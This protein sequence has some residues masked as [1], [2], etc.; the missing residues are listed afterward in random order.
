MTSITSLTLVAISE[1]LPG[2]LFAGIDTHQDTRHVAVVGGTGRPVN[3]CESPAMTT[4]YTQVVA[5]FQSHARTG[6]T[7]G[8]KASR[9]RSMLAKLPWPSSLAPRLDPEKRRWIA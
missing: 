4:G 8:S 6:A 5:F 3:N 7:A 2:S 9:T 1:R